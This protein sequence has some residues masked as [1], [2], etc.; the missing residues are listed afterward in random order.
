MSDPAAM[1][2]TLKTI[3]LGCRVN[4]YETEYV[5]QAFER[6]G[7]REAARGERVDLCVV[8]T[9]SVTAE[10]EAK[11]RKAIRRL[12]KAHPEAEIVVMGCYA[13]RAADQVATL[14]GVVEVVSDKRDLPAL[15][16]RRGL[17][18]VPRGISRFKGRRRA[19]VKVQDGCAMRC[20]YCVVPLVRPHLHS[21]PANEVLEEVARLIACGHRE[22][23]LTGVHLGCYG[24]GPGA[25]VPGS[26]TASPLTGLLRQITDLPGECR[27]R[28]SSIEA[29]EVTPDLIGVMAERAERICPHLHLP[30]QSGSD[31]VLERMN[32]RWTAAQF[33]D[34]CAQV[35]DA[36]DQPAITTD[37]IVGFPG[38]TEQDFA[39]TC[40]VVEQVGFASVHAFR[41]SPRE[42]TPAAQM[43]GQ[44]VNRTTQYRAEQLGKLAESLRDV[45]LNSLGGR[46]LQVL[47]E[48]P[49]RSQPGFVTGTSER[50][51]PVDLP[52][53][54]ELLGRLVWVTTERA[55]AGRIWAMPTE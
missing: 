15:L 16:S 9:C 3:T 29:G 39:A 28:L 26:A 50:H 23:V 34:R 42:G 49:L 4:Q 46:R 37:V 21:R 36:L 40:R 32:R 13:A 11:S 43:N 5:R 33:V 14:P 52:G 27:V 30:L 51:V 20:S 22:I 6:L 38:E 31:R 47:V 48:A 8:N 53:G 18:D 17:R 54:R 41:F 45:Y 55:E 7:Y 12:A 24:R 1:T 25:S 44:V 35:R 2:R 19:Y 10:S